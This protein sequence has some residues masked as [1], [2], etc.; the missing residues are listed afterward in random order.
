MRGPSGTESRDDRKNLELWFSGRWSKRISKLAI[1]ALFETEQ[2]MTVRQSPGGAI[3][4]ERDDM[5]EVAAATLE[6]CNPKNFY[7]ALIRYPDAA[8]L[9]AMQDCGIIHGVDDHDMRQR[10]KDCSVFDEDEEV[11][12]GWRETLGNGRD[13]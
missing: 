4:R 2:R 9:S 3:T 5:H 10:G 7:R 11:I 6:A 1:P 12:N 13:E 8:E